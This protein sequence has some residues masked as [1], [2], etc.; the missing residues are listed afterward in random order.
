MDSG[1]LDR[2]TD[3]GSASQASQSP[4]PERRDFLSTFSTIAM[5]GGLAAGY[6]TF[7]ALAVRYV[8]PTDDETPW[9]YVSPA[10]EI[11]PGE[12]LVFESPVGVKVTIARRLDRKESVDPAEQFI[13]LSSI[14]PHLGCRV[15]WEPH[16]KRFFCPCHN[17]V[18]D[19]EGRP[20]S[21]PPKSAEQELSRYPLKV[22]GGLLYIAISTRSVGSAQHESRGGTH[23]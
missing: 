21:G 18:F 2:A 22:E 4:D 19:P 12:S 13:A 5:A 6:G 1:K 3:P 14:C 23:S 17:G 11:G 9:L 20:V 8:F 15:H 16:N 10:A 7:A